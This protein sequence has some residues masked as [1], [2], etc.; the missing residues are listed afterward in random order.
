MCLVFGS[1]NVSALP[2]LVHQSM[3]TLPMLIHQFPEN[4]ILLEEVKLID[5][6]FGMQVAKQHLCQRDQSSG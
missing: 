3:L 4:I 1:A 6:R 2:M 5:I